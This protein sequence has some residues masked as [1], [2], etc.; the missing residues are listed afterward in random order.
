MARDIPSAV[1]NQISQNNLEAFWAVDLLFDSPNDLYFWSGLGDFS[2]EGNTYTGVGD[3]L[4]ISEIRESTDISAY[5]AVITITGIP[6]S[7]ISLALDEPYQGRKAL[8]RFGTVNAGVSTSFVVFSGDMDQ[9]NISYGPETC[10]ISLEVES[11]LIDLSRARIRRYTDE[12]QRSRF[13]SDSAFSFVNELQDRR[14]T[15]QS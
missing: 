11:R 2:H 8:I 10:T 4:D 13:P 7:R 3:L 6:S 14:V 9:M 15:F 1:T 12:D 5:G